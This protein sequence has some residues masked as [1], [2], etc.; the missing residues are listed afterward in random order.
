MERLINKADR[1][2]DKACM[3]IN[4]KIQNNNNHGSN[5]SVKDLVFMDIGWRTQAQQWIG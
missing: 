4:M 1:E 5:G 2:E 3:G